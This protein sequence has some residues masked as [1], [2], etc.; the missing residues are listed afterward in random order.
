MMFAPWYKFNSVTYPNWEG[1]CMGGLWDS[2]GICCNE[3][4]AGCMPLWPGGGA[5]AIIRG[6]CW[7]AIWGLKGG[8]CCMGGLFWGILGGVSCVGDRSLGEG[9]VS[10]V[11]KRHCFDWKPWISNMKKRNGFAWLSPCKGIKRTTKKLVIY[12]GFQVSN[13]RLQG[14]M[15]WRI[16]T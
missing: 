3:G 15:R 7:A 8:L 6:T 4:L 1:W 16:R 13:N 11:Y 9:A 5:P 10:T 12:K 14:E 2:D